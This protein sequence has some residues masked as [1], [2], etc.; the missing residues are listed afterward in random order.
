MPTPAVLLIGSIP[1]ENEGKCIRRA[2]DAVETLTP[3][4][5]NWRVVQEAACGQDGVATGH[6]SVQKLKPQR[7]PGEM[8]EYVQFNY[9]G[10]VRANYPVFR[11]LRRERG[12][13]HIRFQMGVPTGFAMGFVFAGKLDWLGNTGRS[14]PSS[15]AT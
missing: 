13:E 8:P 2:L 1:F 10:F 11:R 7:S 15:P 5:A 14:I 3:D 6:E 9:D 12:L 4:T